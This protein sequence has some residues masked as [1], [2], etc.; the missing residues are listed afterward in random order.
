MEVKAIQR[1]TYPTPKKLRQ[2]VSLVKNLSPSEAVEVLSFVKKKAAEPLRKVIQ[3][4]I[5]DA[6]RS[7][8]DPNQ[9]VF[10]E[11]QINE[12]PRLKRW[13]AGARSRIKPYQRRMSHVRIV[14]TTR[15][16]MQSVSESRPDAI[17]V[18]KRKQAKKG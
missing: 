17:S 1:Y 16:Q 11:I 13:R 14:L 12:G 7:G 3:S 9:L 15:K 5:A 2:I 10:K 18:T 8:V 4:A 6:L